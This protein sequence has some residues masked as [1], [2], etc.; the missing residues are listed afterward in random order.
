MNELLEAASLYAQTHHRA[1]VALTPFSGVAVLRET[2]PTP[3]LYAVSKPLVALVLQGRKRVSMG[4][5]TL[6]FGAG[7]S[8][9]ICADVPTVSQVTHASSREPYLAL[10]VELD[11]ALIESLV[12]EIGSA[13]FSVN[14]P[15]RVEPTEAEV[16]DTALRLL[17][18]LGKPASVGILQA[19]L[20]RE[21][22]YWLL[23]GR[24]GGAIR[25]LGVTS[26]HAYRISRAIACIR[27]HFAQPLRMEQLAQL[28]GMS[29]S[30]FHTHF[31]MT[32]S[33]TPL[34]Y[35]KQLR[36]M[37]ARRALLEGLPIAKAAYDVGYESIP[38][39]TR[40]YGR[41]FGLPPATDIR[42]VKLR[43]SAARFDQPDR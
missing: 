36:L 6:E 27:E 9:V 16:A 13:P 37:E 35:Q 43:R 25:A 7:E 15:L 14:S 8:L 38:Q 32:T 12:L 28:A 19:Q 21:L 23:S 20:L 33:L 22:H 4:N 29:L 42:H 34:Q 17:R 41:L 39:F 3:L 26:S 2:L 24:H 5:A 30:G 31:R 10:V 18:L 11:Q 1:G 40:E